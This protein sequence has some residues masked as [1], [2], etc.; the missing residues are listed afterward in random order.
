[1]TPSVDG[2]T[3]VVRTLMIQSLSKSPTPEHCTGAKPSTHEPVGGHFT[4]KPYRRPCVGQKPP[5]P[6]TPSQQVILTALP[7]GELAGRKRMGSRV[8]G[9]YTGQGADT[10]AGVDLVVSRGRDPRSA[11]SSPEQT[12][13]PQCHN[14]SD[15]RGSRAHGVNSFL[16]L[17]FPGGHTLSSTVATASS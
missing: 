2:S 11:P 17:R 3:D 5:A 1:M 7:Q 14:G 15:R 10:H 8:E 13:P 12:P 9:Q 6:T 16:P 4:S